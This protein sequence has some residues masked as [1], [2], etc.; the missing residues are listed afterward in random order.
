MSLALVGIRH[1]VFGA[2]GI[3]AVPKLV[4]YYA[5][6]LA[7][8]GVPAVPRRYLS[9]NRNSVSSMSLRVVEEYRAGGAF[10]VVISAHAVPDSDPLVSLAGGYARAYDD[11]ALVF[12]VSD[13]G[14]LAPFAALRLAMAYPERQRVLVIA[15][16]QSAVPFNDP[17]M[18]ELD[19]TVDHAVGL[20]LCPRE[21]RPR[22]LRPQGTVTVELLPTRAGVPRH[23]V[24]SAV[25]AALAGRDVDLV[26]TGPFVTAV[27]GWT[28]R[29][30]PR[31]QLCT[32]V[33]SVLA[34]EL[35]TDELTTPATRYRRI[36]VADYE[37]A[38]RYLCLA[39]LDIPPDRP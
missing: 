33:W 37:P 34:D 12:A 25:R 20:L 22:E 11:G 38:L 4:G 24:G 9:G 30:A 19:P 6:R 5:E 10:D 39:I 32:S 15:L 28:V 36:A 31:D 16:D 2:A 13:Q 23:L 18:A 7:P 26:V 14:R 8:Y 1:T 17:G 27:T 35:T 3:P 21:P 29:P